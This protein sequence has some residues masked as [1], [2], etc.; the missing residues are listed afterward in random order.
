MAAAPGSSS[1]LPSVSRRGATLA[2]VAI[3]VLLLIAP[4][5][6]IAAA[7][8]TTAVA[9]AAIVVVPTWRPTPKPAAAAAR[10]RIALG[11]TP[12]A[13]VPS[14]A[15][16]STIFSLDLADDRDDEG[17]GATAVRR[18]RGPHHLLRIDGV[19]IHQD[20]RRTVIE[21]IFLGKVFDLVAKSRDTYLHV[22]GA[23]TRAGLVA[24][25]IS[26][27]RRRPCWAPRSGLRHDAGEGHQPTCHSPSG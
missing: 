12:G 10:I 23:R 21:A 11:L 9:A 16:W 19:H 4:T 14:I 24:V 17:N 6:A 20:P 27:L 25:A 26:L 22:L 5:T 2:A 15:L 3:V 18:Q 7:T 1:A 8:T 13:P